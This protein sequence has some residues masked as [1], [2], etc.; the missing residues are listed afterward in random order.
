MR[1]SVRRV[2]HTRFAAFRGLTDA[3]KIR[4]IPSRGARSGAC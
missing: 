3:A 2:Y 4:N 1:L